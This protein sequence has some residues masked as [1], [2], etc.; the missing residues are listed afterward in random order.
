MKTRML[1]L[2]ACLIFGAGLTSC[3]KNDLAGKV[4]ITFSFTFNDESLIFVNKDYMI[5]SGNII[6]IAGIQYF[7]SD[8]VFVGQHGQSRGFRQE[9]NRIH[10]VDS[11]LPATLKW[12]IDEPL[13][14]DIY[15]YVEF[16]YGLDVPYNQ[17]GRF[18]NAPESLMFW[19]ESMGG[20]YHHLKLNG[21]YALNAGDTVFYPFGFHAGI[22]TNA[23]HLRDTLRL[24]LPDGFTQNLN[25]NMEVAHWFVNPNVWDFGQFSGS[26]MQNMEAQRV[27]KENAHDVFSIR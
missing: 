24:F 16:V 11:D 13:Q 26:V 25:L 9:R 5:A 10:Y 3:H 12:E 7:I 20:G 15:D 21:W 14:A 1:L 23:V 4:S 6:R 17:T 27:I 19:P 18:L 2:S 8:P 22:D